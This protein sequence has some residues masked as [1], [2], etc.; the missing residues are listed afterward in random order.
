MTHTQMMAMCPCCD[1]PLISTMAFRRFEFYCLEC[2]S[3]FGFIEPKAAKATDELEARHTELRAEWDEHV[4]GKLLSDGGWHR[5]CE[6]C[7]AHDRANPHAAHAT[8]QEVADHELALA[9]LAARV[10]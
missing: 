4:G 2:G 5:D 3:K 8:D 1:V 6:Q 10:K 9:W 7:A